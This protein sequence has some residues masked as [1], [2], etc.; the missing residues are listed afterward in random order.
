M[1]AASAATPHHPLPAHTPGWGR[2]HRPL[3]AWAPLPFPSLHAPADTYSLRSSPA[4]SEARARVSAK[5][6]HGCTGQQQRLSSWAGPPRLAAAP[7][8]LSGSG[9]GFRGLDCTEW[10]NKLARDGQARA[11]RAPRRPAPPTG[12]GR[13]FE[14]RSWSRRPRVSPT[15][16]TAGPFSL[17]VSL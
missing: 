7:R 8:F 5:A 14:V 12:W 11:A 13:R 4:I 3:S 15:I 16:A 17:Y 6:F 1:R 2:S 9:D 10:M